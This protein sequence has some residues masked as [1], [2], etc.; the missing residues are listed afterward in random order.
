MVIAGAKG[1]WGRT[2]ST[3]KKRGMC[4][5]SFPDY[6]VALAALLVRLRH[7]AQVRLGCLPAIGVFLLRIFV[8]HRGYDDHIL[9]RLPVYRRVDLVSG[10]ELHRIEHAQHF[11][12]GAARAH[13]A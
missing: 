2:A 6:P 3:K 7:D 5:A 11:V 8:G 9:A 1:A 4:R 10:G 12:E 13:R